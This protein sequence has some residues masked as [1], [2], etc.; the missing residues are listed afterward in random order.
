MPLW[1]WL[2][3][4]S[5]TRLQHLPLL[6]SPQADAEMLPKGAS[7][8]LIPKPSFLEILSLGLTWGPRHSNDLNWQGE[9]TSNY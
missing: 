6:I 7:Q 2:Q 3:A 5:W 8:W 1:V 4:L 9:V